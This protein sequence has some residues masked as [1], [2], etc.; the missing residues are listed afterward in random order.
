MQVFA[1]E[2]KGMLAY[3]EKLRDMYNMEL[4]EL[5]PGHLSCVKRGGRSNFFGVTTKDGKRIRKGITKD[6]HQIKLLA[7]K[8]YIV[9]VL[10]LIERNIGALKQASNQIRPIDP[11]Q[12]ASDIPTQIGDLPK[13]YFLRSDDSMKVKLLEANQFIADLSFKDQKIIREKCQ[14][15]EAWAEE[16][17]Q[18]IVPTERT[19]PH[20][21][22]RGLIDRKSVV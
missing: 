21:T 20:M 12:I 19:H 15:H 8:E 5:P 6:E 1:D 2:I 14:R 13:E 7:R 9:R 10:P 18:Q 17:Y 4:A 11:R 3:Y 16:E 22:S